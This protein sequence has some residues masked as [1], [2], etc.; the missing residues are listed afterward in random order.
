[1]SNTKDIAYTKYPT[2]M[3]WLHHIVAVL[4]IGCYFLADYKDLHVSLG[5]LLLIFGCIRVFVRLLNTSKT[6]PSINSPKSWQYI[7]EKAV[8]ILL[9]ILIFLQSILG[10]I[11]SNAK[12]NPV[13]LFGMVDFP[14]LLGPNKAVFDSLYDIH[15]ALGKVFLRY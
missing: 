9:F 5:A 3:I 10:W 12:G 14:L 13:T 4:M 6:P 8:H 11:I 1:M 2:S 7:I 15:E